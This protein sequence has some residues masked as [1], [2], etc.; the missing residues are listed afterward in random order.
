MQDRT[1]GGPGSWHGEIRGLRRV[2]DLLDRIAE[3]AVSELAV[4]VA[5]ARA[6]PARD[7]TGPVGVRWRSDLHPGETPRPPPAGERVLAPPLPTRAW[8]P[9]PGQAPAGLPSAVLV[10]LSDGDEDGLPS[11]GPRLELH[12][13]TPDFFG[14]PELRA[15]ADFAAYAA[16]S[17]RAV[18]R[19]ANLSTALETRGAISQAQGILME[20]F[21]LD[22]EAAM[23]LMRRL[24]Q[25][26]HR[27]IRDLAN[28]IAGG[29]APLPGTGPGE[30][31]PWTQ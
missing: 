2:D 3:R 25:H 14:P 4:T 31:L 24:S 15:A 29:E 1:S 13:D 30:W 12:A 19:V 20:R 16:L 21:E 27:P 17:L 8:W 18:Q 23:S 7:G 26:S 11:E 28:D 10:D 9:A 5:V 22:P 6:K